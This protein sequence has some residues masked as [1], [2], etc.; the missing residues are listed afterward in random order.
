MRAS[1]RAL[2][3]RKSPAGCAT[4]QL[5]LFNHSVVQHTVTDS[6]ALC[7]NHAESA[8]GT[9]EAR[10][11]RGQEIAIRSDITR[12]G[13]V[14]IVP[15]QTSHKRYTV[16]LFLQTCTCADFDSHHLKCK[17]IYAA[18][19]TFNHENGAPLPVPEMVVKPTYKQEWKE[20]RLAQVNEKAKFL[21]LL[22]ALCSELEEAPQHMGRP[23]IPLADRLFSA[24]F[25]VYECLSG[26]RFMSDLMEAKRR[27]LISQMP[28]FCTIFRVLESEAVTPVLKQM[29]ADSALPLK[30]IERNFA[31]DS[32][33]FSTGQFA[34]W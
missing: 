8:I 17:H 29:I 10:Q 30:S 9:M 15:S 16:S 24:V 4:N 27:G 23:R 7:L 18:E 11:L 14:W 3:Q 33:G 6:S 20:Y 19:A 21:E 32:S 25:K 28:N 26:R 13:N 5:D 2:R 34:R 12:E 1:L 31:V 22:Y